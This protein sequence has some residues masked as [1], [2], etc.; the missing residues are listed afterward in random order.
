MRV[1]GISGAAAS[2]D[3]LSERLR[4]SSCSR[5]TEL[6]SAFLRSI[7]LL[8]LPWWLSGK[9]SAC[10][11]KRCG[12]DPWPGQIP[13]ATEQ[14]SPCPTSTEPRPR[15]PETATTEPTCL[16]FWSSHACSPC[17]GTRGTTMRGPHTV[18]R[19]TPAH[20]NCRKSPHSN[21]DPAQRKT[22]IFFRIKKMFSSFIWLPQGLVAAGGIS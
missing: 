10:Q 9:E 13:R 2:P 16:N 14:L 5:P 21:K 22:N 11:C 6:E 4:L 1:S 20:C 8:G 18:T 15:S 7:Y 12:F 17:S 3:S 19:V